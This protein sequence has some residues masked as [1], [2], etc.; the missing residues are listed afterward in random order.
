MR[1]LIDTSAYSSFL[2]GNTKVRDLL[3]LADT[4]YFNP[5]VLGELKAGF[6][7]GRKRRDNEELLAQFLESPRVYLVPI[8]Q[9][10]SERYAVIRNSLWKS[11]T[12]I[13]TNDLWISATAMQHGLVVVTTD[14]H[15]RRI[16]QILVEYLPAE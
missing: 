13:P 4:I 15:Y 12:P 14:P 11:G 9:E 6:Q 7:R 1:V 2:R 3:Q 10:T 8:D 5:I 16:M